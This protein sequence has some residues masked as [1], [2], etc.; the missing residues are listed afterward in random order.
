VTQ[1]ISA[2]F[3]LSIAVGLLV[4]ALW[5]WQSAD[6]IVAR[7]QMSGQSAMWGVRCAAIGIG[8][9]AQVLILTVIGRWVYSRDTVTDVLRLCGVLVFML[10]G[11]VAVA[12]AL[13]GR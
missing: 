11:V 12:L 8:A 7:G 3:G 10:A 9:A 13:A 4:I 1:R 5:G 2:I 6:W